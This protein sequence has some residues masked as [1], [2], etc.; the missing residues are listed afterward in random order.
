MVANQSY[1]AGDASKQ[2]VL[3]VWVGEPGLVR[4]IPRNA[5]AGR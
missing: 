1:F 2:A 3:D 5:G 4:P